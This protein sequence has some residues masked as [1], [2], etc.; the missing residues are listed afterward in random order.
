M[1]NE[2]KGL[3]KNN[4]AKYEK[5]AVEVANELKNFIKCMR[6][7]HKDTEPFLKNTYQFLRK[8]VLELLNS[9][10]NEAIIEE[11][12]EITNY[13]YLY[14]L[15]QTSK[16][17]QYVNQ[18]VFITD[19]RQ[20]KPHYDGI[21]KDRDIYK[22]LR[23]ASIL[24]ITHPLLN[25]PAK[26][27]LRVSVSQQELFSDSYLDE[28]KERHFYYNQSP[29]NINQK[30]Q[31]KRHSIKDKDKIS[32]TT[33]LSTA[34]FFHEK[35]K[36][37]AF[38]YS[39]YADITTHKKEHALFKSAVNTIHSGKALTKAEEQVL[40]SGVYYRYNS[41]I[42]YKPVIKKQ[43][44]NQEKLIIQTTNPFKEINRDY[45]IT[46][47]G[48]A[49]ECIAM[50]NILPIHICI[51]PVLYQSSISEMNG[52]KPLMLHDQYTASAF[53]AEDYPATNV[54]LLS[55]NHI[56]FI[57][58]SFL[59]EAFGESNT[60]F[61]VPAGNAGQMHKIGIMNVVEM[62]SWND[63]A[64]INLSCQTGKSSNYEIR[65]F[66]ANHASSHKSAKRGCT[67][68]MG[69]MIRDVTKN[70]IIIC[71]SNTAALAPSH[72][73]QLEHYLLE[74]SCTISTACITHGPDRSQSVMEC[75]HQ[76][77]ADMLAMHAEFNVMNTRVFAK[78]NNIDPYE[79][80]FEQV[81]QSACYA[82]GYHQGYYRL[83]LINLREVDASLLKFVAVLKSCDPK[84]INELNKALLQK[85]VFFNFMNT[86][87]QCSLMRT[88]EV[89]TSLKIASGCLT[90]TQ[91]V[92]IITS[93]LNIPQPGYRSDF[94]KEV[95]YEPYNFAFERLIVNRNPEIT[96]W[97]DKG[98]KGAFEH[99][100]YLLKPEFYEGA[101]NKSALVLKFLTIY[102]NMQ[103]DITR[104]KPSNDAVIN[105]F[106]E[107]LQG[108]IK[109]EE[110]DEH[111]GSLYALLFPEKDTY[112]WDEGYLHTA[113]I[114]IAGLLHFPDFR[115]TMHACYNAFHNKIIISDE[116]IEVT[117]GGF[118]L[119]H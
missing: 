87:E 109:E 101:F 119:G 111:L 13:Y 76:S 114:I 25:Q 105:F 6:N 1:G 50:Q 16:F 86:F 73:Q 57:G 29:I 52:L 63:I 82:I 42:K 64:L 37:S 22:N 69:Y 10:N 108:A 4:A 23:K 54:V 67:L 30:Y 17:N 41:P 88:L 104:I 80:T 68:D 83:S 56:D 32:N 51:N 75:L 94:S 95:P 49:A 113:L 24:P 9:I 70:D 115:K 31:N 117:K 15:Q 5:K 27:T 34:G 62:S 79:L 85:N 97:I 35:S 90:T 39:Q 53:S 12:P 60:L 65:A 78:R 96:D 11:L 44:K 3:Q 100:C 71:I 77:T 46:H 98:F 93:H 28:N 72:F 40:K 61:I 26:T 107:L 74:N 43:N 2:N 8:D 112:I 102:L 91:L 7:H 48:Q 103:K 118:S 84:P 21:N 99:F 110:L 106:D 20:S 58:Q 18:K 59:K 92:A 55:H 19:L 38:Y 45:Q 47:L 14:L 116:E 89:Y 81:H 33:Q 66:P 36:G